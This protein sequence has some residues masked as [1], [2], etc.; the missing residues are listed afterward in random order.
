MKKIIVL[1]L[2]CVSVFST[3]SLS[4]EFDNILQSV[5]VVESTTINR[6]ASLGTG[7]YFEDHYIITNYHVVK[8][9][10]TFTIRTYNDF[11]PVDAT[12]VGY[13]RYTDLAI[14]QTKTVGPRIIPIKS[15]NVQLG[16][17]VF[18]VGHPFGYEFTISKGVISSLDRYD[19]KYP[20]IS[21]LQTDANVQSGSSGSP[22][23]NQH[24]KVIGIVKATVNSTVSAGISLAITLPLITDSIKKIKEQKV[25]KR[26]SLIFISD[27]N[28]F[29]PLIPE[30]NL[31]LST[32]QKSHTHIYSNK[33]TGNIVLHSINGTEIHSTD[34]ANRIIQ[35]YKPG[36]SVKIVYRNN[37]SF[38]TQTIKLENLN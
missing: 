31:Q 12:L 36:E 37:N 38:I 14:L 26:P 35:S 8:D 7:F 29:K 6:P 33:K 30:T 5:V 3:K 15:Q 18:V 28:T 17:D 24:G 1:W 23:L 19:S 20:F 9:Y 32:N 34:E 4:I 21:Y 22:V 13:D 2:M 16:E 25:V 11:G 27:K 10:K